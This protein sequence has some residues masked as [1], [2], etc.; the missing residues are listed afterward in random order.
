MRQRFAWVGGRLVPIELEQP[1]IPL[2]LPTEPTEMQ[3]MIR[4]I[5]DAIGR[6]R[7]PAVIRGRVTIT[8]MPD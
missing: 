4:S 5:E 2:P 1:I 8:G 7:L 3:E 6:C